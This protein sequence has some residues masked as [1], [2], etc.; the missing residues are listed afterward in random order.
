MFQYFNYVQLSVPECLQ[1][2]ALFILDKSSLN[3]L[4]LA[5]HNFCLYI[6]KIDLYIAIIW[7][8]F[9]ICTYAKILKFY[10]NLTLM[11]PKVKFIGFFILGS[12]LSDYSYSIFADY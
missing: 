3:Q 10:L 1:H 7:L 5:F 11:Y 6:S 2:S 8:L 9:S 4:A 12:V